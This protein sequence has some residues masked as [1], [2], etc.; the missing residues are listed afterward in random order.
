MKK[1]LL[2]TACLVF[3]GCQSGPRAK[4]SADAA[5]AAN[6]AETAKSRYWQLQQ[7]RPDTEAPPR[8]RRLTISI[9]AHTEAGVNYDE[10]TR[11]ILIAE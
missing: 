9:P 8:F 4:V 1:T 6:P 10:T 7:S 11:T 5:A 3:G 2:I